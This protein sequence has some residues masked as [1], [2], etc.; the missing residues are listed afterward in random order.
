MTNQS[1]LSRIKR[2]RSAKEVEFLVKEGGKF[3]N[4]SERTRARWQ[5]KAAKRLTELEEA[6]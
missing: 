2:A 3:E 6:E 5:R 1:I 4:A